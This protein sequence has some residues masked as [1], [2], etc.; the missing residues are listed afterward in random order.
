VPA[1]FLDVQNNVRTFGIINRTLLSADE[2]SQARV[3][4]RGSAGSV[5]RQAEPALGWYFPE[6]ESAVG[7]IG[8]SSFSPG[9]RAVPL[10]RKT[11]QCGGLAAVQSPRLADPR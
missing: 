8:A 3:L 6:K 5:T 4:P 10:T 7:L 9:H 2:P 1:R 11:E